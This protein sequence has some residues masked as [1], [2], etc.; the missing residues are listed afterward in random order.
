MIVQ[1]EC[2]L[3]E[4][5]DDIQ[6]LVGISKSPPQVKWKKKRNQATKFYIWSGGS[7]VVQRIVSIVNQYT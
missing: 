5:S 1:Y 4:M 3:R 2:A 6:I 7:M